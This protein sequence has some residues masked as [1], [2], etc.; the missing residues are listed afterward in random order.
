MHPTTKNFPLTEFFWRFVW[1]E[2]NL[3]LKT[4]NKKVYVFVYTYVFPR[5][6][7]SI[8]QF[9]KNWNLLTFYFWAFSDSHN[10]FLASRHKTNGTSPTFL[11]FLGSLRAMIAGRCDLYSLLLVILFQ[12]VPKISEGEGSSLQQTVE[13][14]MPQSAE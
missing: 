11:L 3:V 8:L 13:I 9:A 7:S 14:L 2:M 5:P 4:K 1:R 10:W 12:A 6:A